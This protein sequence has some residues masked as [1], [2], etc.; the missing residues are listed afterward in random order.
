MASDDWL[1][2]GW[3]PVMQV[4]G[5]VLIRKFEWVS[6][7]LFKGRRFEVSA[8][9]LERGPCRGPSHSRWKTQ[10]TMESAGVGPL[11]H[12]HRGGAE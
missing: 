4:A 7:R 5:R 9:F 11:F 8:V 10:N 2:K 3:S 6:R 1:G 12:E